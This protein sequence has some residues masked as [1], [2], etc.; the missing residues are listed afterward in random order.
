MGDLA[1]PTLVLAGQRDLV[2]TR[3]IA[4]FLGY[5]LP[6]GRLEVLEG[7]GHLLALED[8]DEFTERVVAFLGDGGRRMGSVV[9][10][11]PGCAGDE[12]L[13]GPGSL[14]PFAGFVGGRWEMGDQVQSLEWAPGRKGVVA[15]QFRVVDGDGGRAGREERLEEVSRLFWAWDPSSGTFEGRGVAVGMGIDQFVLSTSF[16][17]GVMVSDVSAF[18]PRAPEGVLREEW[19]PEGSDRYR[20]VLLDED[21]SPIMEGA[22]T[23]SWGA[24]PG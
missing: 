9:E 8:P 11:P 10:P 23:R 20:W 14:A 4:A 13:W 1:V 6:Q 17:D 24:P 7:R 21:G 18:G 22:W 3:R 16:T 15:R 19:R 12:D 2:D 5:C